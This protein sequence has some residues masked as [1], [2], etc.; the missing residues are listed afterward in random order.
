MAY[1]HPVSHHDQY[2]DRVPGG[3]SYDS[4]FYEKPRYQSYCLGM[5][6]SAELITLKAIAPLPRSAGLNSLNEATTSAASLETWFR[7]RAHRFKPAA[8]AHL[9]MLSDDCRGRGDQR[10]RPCRDTC[11]C[12]P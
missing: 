6:C 12:A 10:C 2:C 11:H 3:P 9:G 8:D 5:S 4:G 1:P 7:R